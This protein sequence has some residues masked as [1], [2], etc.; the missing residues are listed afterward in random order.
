MTIL[1][2]TDDLDTGKRLGVI[3]RR[4][5]YRVHTAR[6]REGIPQA[7]AHHPEL[8]LLDARLSSPGSIAGYRALCADSG[9]PMLTLALDGSGV[10][11]QQR[12]R[13]SASAPLR[14]IVP[15][16]DLVA[17]VRTLL[18]RGQ[19]PAEQPVRLGPLLLNP[20][21]RT[22]L[23]HGQPLTLRAK[24]FD[25]LLSFARHPGA[26]LRREQLLEQAWGYS[27]A[28]KTRTVDVHVAHLRS[29]LAGSGLVIQT[30]RGAGYLL[31]HEPD[32]IGSTAPRPESD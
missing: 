3:L 19:T 9:I 30:R 26:V 29:K 18:H 23:L 25:L 21:E 8:V 1:I 10:D 31:V 4:E 28:G 5:G 13:P 2:V 20:A 22:A 6:G 12:I 32:G 24:E 15:D 14:R 16:R 17:H 27:V 11:E 7:R